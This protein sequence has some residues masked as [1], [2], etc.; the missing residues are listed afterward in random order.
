MEISR[1]YLVE[2]LA[3]IFWAGC[4]LNYGLLNESPWALVECYINVTIHC[5]WIACMLK[6]TTVHNYSDHHNLLPSGRATT[7][8]TGS[9]QSI[10]Y[11]WNA[12]RYTPR[13][14]LIMIHLL[15]PQQIN[16]LSIYIIL[17]QMAHLSVGDGE[18]QLNILF[19]VSWVADQDRYWAHCIL[20]TEWVLRSVFCLCVMPSIIV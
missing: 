10:Q 11:D 4:R 1:V 3:F 12:H 18:S 13:N 17:T 9:S 6:I 5:T 16:P 15:S 14:S 7:A 8:P 19:S 20:A 2:G